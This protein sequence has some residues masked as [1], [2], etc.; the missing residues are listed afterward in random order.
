MKILLFYQVTEQK[1][2]PVVGEQTYVIPNNPEPGVTPNN[3]E[4]YVIPNNPD[5]HL[6][7]GPNNNP[8]QFHTYEYPL[9][10][11]NHHYEY[12]SVSNLR[13]SNPSKNPE[14]NRNEKADLGV[15]DGD[16]TPLVRLPQEGSE[17][18]DNEYASLINVLKDKGNV[19]VT[20]EPDRLVNREDGVYTQLVR[21]PSKNNK[22]EDSGYAPLINVR[23]KK[24]NAAANKTDK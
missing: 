4:A 15:Q 1:A 18:G 3:S 12:P 17:R 19:E 8:L 7:N 5:Q 2:S 10:P 22:S 23:K 9:L 20:D 11:I 16:Y 6:D 21:S 14:E 13:S 24:E